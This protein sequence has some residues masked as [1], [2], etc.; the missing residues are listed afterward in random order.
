MPV[1][2]GEILV[3]QWTMLAVERHYRDLQDGS[4]RG[5]LFSPAHANHVID[6]IQGWFVHIKGP[7]AREPILLDHWQLFWTAV[8]F[9][10]RRTSDGHRRFRTGY[11][12]VARKN[13]K[14]TWMG[15]VGAYLWMMDGE[16]G[17]EVYS[18]ATTR[19]QAMAVFKPAFD[20][21]KR[22]CRRSPKLAKSIRVHDGA[23]QEKMT[24]GESV[25]KPLPANAESL[26]GLN[27]YA[28][29]VDELHAHKTREVWD[30][31]ESALGA[32]TQPLINAITT[33][34]FILDGICVEIRTYLTKVLKGEVIDDQ[35]FGVIYTLDEGDDPFD[36]FNWSKA[37]PS[38]GSAKTISYMEAQAAKAKVMP[39]ARAN[40][41]TKDLN[42]FVGDSLSWFDLT[43]W[44]RG[45]RKFDPDMLKGRRCFGGLDLAATRDLTAFCLLFP[46]PD[47]DEAGDWFALV[48]T[49]CP[50]AKVD[51][52]EQDN[53]SDYRRWAKQHWLSVTDGDVTDYA[54]VKAVI[55]QALLDYE[56]VEIAFDTWNST[57][58]ANELIERD[59]PMVKLPQN[60]GG[61]SPGSKLLE[62]LVYSKRFQHG[63]NPVLRWCAGNV[64]LLIDSN[65]NCKPDK[66]RSQGRI[67]PIVALCM[68][69]TRAL[70]HMDQSSIYEESGIRTL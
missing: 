58:I 14:S 53:G 6:F 50:Q 47:G 70:V 57:H 3:G 4:K 8:L 10:W 59:A 44:D 38:L 40:F 30:V 65:E 36:P 62:R 20:N 39:S 37:N 9:G 32:R 41:M 29:L 61:L 67:D 68:A 56:V 27:P 24:L 48:W 23:N 11:E 17:A 51:D 43:V 33:A 22:W 69:A 28:C 54:P 60:F 35:F 16:G 18:I 64:T 34:G 49:W 12:E 26:D 42:I 55:L 21:V 31:M 15:P 5:L 7:L 19:E 25:Y 63:G 52:A 13:G 2:R 46:P 1:L 66:K 45:G